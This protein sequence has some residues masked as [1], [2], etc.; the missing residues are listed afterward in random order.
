MITPSDVFAR[1][2]PE[3]GPEIELADKVRR[4]SDPATFG[5]AGARVKAV[6]THMSWVFLAGDFAYKL[7]KPVRFP[8][9]DFSTLE[10]R[11]ADC[12]AE[13]ELNRRLAPDVYLRVVPLTR[14]AVGFVVGSEGPVAD[15]LV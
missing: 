13:L 7:K 3:R 8:F 10:A 5:L 1:S 2:G 15:W 12:R 4:L 9:L 14:A 11:E 6:E